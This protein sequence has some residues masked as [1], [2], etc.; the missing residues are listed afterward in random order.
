MARRLK[1]ISMQTYDIIMIVVLVAATVW[2]LWKGLAWQLAS[3]ASIFLSYFVACQFREP[4]AQR[5]NA[6]PPWGMFLAM[7][8]LFLVTS[9]LVWI[10][11]R[12]VRQFIDRLKL[13]EFDRQVGAVMG[14]GTGMILCIVITLFSLTLLSDA[15]RQSII[16]SRS[17]R[18]IAMLLDKA[19][20][21]MPKEVQDVLHPHLHAVL[22]EPHVQVD[23]E[24]DAGEPDFHTADNHTN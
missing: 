16:N 5:I 23:V 8:I 14:M 1:G 19:H 10:V 15:Q 6:T 18:Y 4:V 7:L 22:D 3:L 21:I 13:N 11:F 12:F 20:P 24:H 9:L 17:G 2:G